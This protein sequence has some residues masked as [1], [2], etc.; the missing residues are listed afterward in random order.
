MIASR[1][2]DTLEAAQSGGSEAPGPRLIAVGSGKGGVGKSFL[3]ANVATVLARRPCEVAAVDGDLEGANLHT[4][5]GLPRPLRSLA[6][7]VADREPD[8]RKLLV[9][10]RTPGLR[11]V[12]GTDANLSSPQPGHRRR[13]RMLAHLRALPVD[14]VVLDLGAGTD[15]AVMD[16]FLAGDECVLVTTP[17]P[18]AIENAYGFLRTAFYR[19]L[20]LSMV[21]HEVRGLVTEAMDQRN[22]RGIRTPLDLL[23]EIE[24]RDPEEGARF[25]AAVRSF[26]PRIVVNGV[27]TAQEIRLGFG[28]RSVCRKY[29]GIEAE[30]LG[31]V[32]HEEA[33]RR[34]VLARRPLVEAD[35]NCDAAIYLERIARKLAG[36]GARGAPA[37]QGTGA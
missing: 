25:V 29:F 26:R 2:A 28:M 19:R 31:Y 35:P 21:T 36:P 20:R 15:P 22:E 7:F 33:V 23:R 8:L 37:A 18:T 27:R 1:E 17:E 10:T 34:S 5:L 9:E 4:C 3:A 30:Y 32:N 11:L 12:A 6:D 16:Y 13:L 24:S 14:A